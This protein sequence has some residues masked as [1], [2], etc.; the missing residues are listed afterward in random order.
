[1]FS[2]PALNATLNATSALLLAGGYAAIRAGK[3]Q[4]HKKFMVSAFWVSVVFLVSYVIYHLRV[5]QVV[6]F[7]GQGWIRPVYFA[8]LLSHT[9]LAIVIVPMIL[10]TL[11]RAWMERF[12][13]HKIIARW[14]LPLWF[15][16]CVTGVIVYFMVYQIYAAKNV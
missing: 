15:Y 2:Q 10:V 1:M 3:M 11:R 8:L 16:V 14:T 12:D 9:V 13:K 6:L 7:Q 5:R 4:V